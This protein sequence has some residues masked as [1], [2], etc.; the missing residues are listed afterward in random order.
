MKF[1]RK[2]TN[3]LSNDKLK[4][5]LNEYKRYQ[6]ECGVDKNRIVHMNK[7]AI[8]KLNEDLHLDNVSEKQAQ[9]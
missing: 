7:K 5:V 2:T 9:E 6:N 3:K 4:A 8:L 1:V